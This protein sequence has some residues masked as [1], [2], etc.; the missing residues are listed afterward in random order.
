[1]MHYTISGEGK[2]VV[3]IHGFG[4]D[5]RIWNRQVEWMQK[6]FKVIVPDLPGTGRTPVSVELTMESMAAGIKQILDK[7]GIKKCTLLGHSMGGYI[8]LAFAELFPALLEGL[9]L[10][11][12]SAFADNETKKEA[13][14]KSIDFISKHG[15]GPFLEAST[16]NLF[17]EKNRISMNEQIRELTER[18][19]YMGPAALIA[20]YNA[21]IARPDRTEILKTAP[22]PVLFLIGR[23]DQAILFSDSMQQVYLPELSYI[24]ILDKSGHMGMLEEPLLFN[25]ALFD[26]LSDLPA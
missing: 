14:R 8:S 23:E 11:H 18:H 21:M 20:F 25:K 19:L 22:F 3:L 5:S 1:M 16:P 17:T 10:L 4:E 13:R 12:S 9:G 7:E 6:S 2:T 15:A 26:F 24:Y